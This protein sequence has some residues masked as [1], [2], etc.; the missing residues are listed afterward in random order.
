MPSNE[1]GHIARDREFKLLGQS[2][3]FA[4]PTQKSLVPAS[5]TSLVAP[6]P[7]IEEDI[8]SK[9]G[10]CGSLRNDGDMRD[11]RPKSLD[12][13]PWVAPGNVRDSLKKVF[14]II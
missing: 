10:G 2:P 9:K 5:G 7:A 1:K 12:F 6:C 3:L 14:F 11:P 4:L 13:I 8:G